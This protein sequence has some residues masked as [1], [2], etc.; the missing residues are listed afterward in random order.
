MRWL[1][2]VPVAVVLVYLLAANLFLRL[3]G[4][5][6]ALAGADEV[7]VT[8]QRAWSLWPGRVHIEDFRIAFEDRNLQFSI[9]IPHVDVTVQLRALLRQTF[10]ATQVNGSGLVFRVRKRVDPREADR[11][12]VRA[13]P[14][15]NDFEDPALYISGPPPPPR[16]YAHFHPWTLHIEN[17]DVEV[18]ELWVQ[19]LRYQGTARATGAFRLIPATR[20]WVGPATLRFASGSVVTGPV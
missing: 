17:V 12:V 15:V 3:G 2:V 18:H 16:D 20:L 11:P 13:F 4:V 7:E 5:Q 9:E 6:M 14:P 19:M 1:A 8:F 10:Y